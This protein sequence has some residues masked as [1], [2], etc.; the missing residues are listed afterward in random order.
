MSRFSFISTTP[1]P[2]RAVLV[3]VE[4]KDAQWPLER[5]LDELER[6][7]HTAGAISV[8]RLSQKL[9]KP[10]PKS[11]IGSGKVE[12]L[13]GLVHRM[14]L[15]IVIFDDDLT[16]SQQSYLEKAVGEPVKIIDRTALILDIFGLHA[17]TREGRLQ[18]QLAQCEY[19]L[20]RLRGMWSH[21]AKEQTRGGIGGRFGQGESQLEVDRRLVRNRIS[22]LKRDLKEV[23]K[24]REVQSKTRSESDACRVALAGYTNAGK[25]TLL[26]TLTGSSV[27]SQDKLF[28]TLDPTTRSYA[29]PGGRE[30]TVT[31]TVGF[32]QKLPHGLVNAFKSTLS[33]VLDSDLILKVVDASDEDYIRH[34]EAV[35]AVLDEIGAGSQ[36]AVIVFN[37]IDLLEDNDRRYLSRRYPDA[38]L[39]SAGTGEGLANLLRRIAR[40]ASV[41]EVLLSVSIP[42]SQGSLLSL[43]HEQ[44]SIISESYQSEGV[45]IVVKVSK[46]LEHRLKPYSVLDN[47][48]VDVE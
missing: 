23:E 12:E 28:A 42:Y 48:T 46:R 47:L 26:N 9:V 30:M 38:V 13:V 29:L 19:L 20:P 25:S 33:E 22:A 10:N 41:N 11:F 17:Q 6:L 24:R 14:D 39:F 45:N 36:P 3:G 44:G 34:L 8:V 35:D 18:V 7:A 27:L 31:D 1:E 32:I 37:K 5:S 4:W 43:I 15:D 21:L 40:E 16:P 2:E